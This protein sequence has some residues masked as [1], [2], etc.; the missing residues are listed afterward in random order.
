MANKEVKKVV[1]CRIC[2]SKDLI[3]VLDLGKQPIPNGFL[4][5]KDLK[6]KEKRYPLAVVF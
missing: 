3:D 6:K 1:N 2:N 5:E 4:S